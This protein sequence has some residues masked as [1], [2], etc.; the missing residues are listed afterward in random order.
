MKKTLI[1][2]AITLWWAAMMA[3]LLWRYSDLGPGGRNAPPLDTLT[4]ADA[5]TD[6]EE[7]MEVKWNGLTVGYF[8]SF[9]RRV[10]LA[11]SSEEEGGPART[12]S[13][14]R[15]RAGETAPAYHAGVQGALKFGPLEGRVRASTLLDERLIL[16]RFSVATDLGLGQS[17]ADEEAEDSAAAGAPAGPPSRIRVDGVA[18]G[19]ALYLRI[20]RGEARRFE[21]VNLQRPV[22]L[23]DSLRPFYAR[24]DLAEGDAYSVPVFDPLWNLQGGQMVIRYRGREEIQ[25][26]GRPA[27]VDALKFETTLG[28]IRGTLWT[29]ETGAVLRRI[30]PPLQMDTVDRE[31]VV[32]R[33]PWMAR[34][35]EPP[36]VRLSDVQGESTGD[37]LAG[38]GLFGLLQEALG[39]PLS[40]AA[41]GAASSGN[42]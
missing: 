15:T 1:A 27:K 30:M 28:S 4:L 29:D 23:A 14:R 24:A 36:H 3:A 6:Q 33:Y 5:W 42:P 7:W 35:P 32:A 37:P 16:D 2:A 26:T 39:S 8:H 10:F 13:R 31:T 40:P 11:P 9:A 41:P 18:R 34:A 19:R 12:R 21:T 25:I 22:A 17:R 38:A 20:E